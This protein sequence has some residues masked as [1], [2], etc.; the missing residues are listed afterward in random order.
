MCG[1]F[2]KWGGGEGRKG[3]F[4]NVERKKVPKR[5]KDVKIKR[6]ESLG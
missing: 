3:K 6:I 4:R 1:M 5:C 2:V